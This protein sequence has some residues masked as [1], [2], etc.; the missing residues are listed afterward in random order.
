[1]NLNPLESLKTANRT[2]SL[3]ELNKKIKNMHS[4]QSLAFH[5]SYYVLT[6]TV[7]WNISMPVWHI[8]ITFSFRKAETT[9]I[10]NGNILSSKENP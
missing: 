8:L 2:F 10:G 3:S 6:A 4:E 7:F 9:S 5:G 1:M